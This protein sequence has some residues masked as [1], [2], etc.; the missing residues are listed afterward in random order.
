[1]Y[2]IITI[3]DA[4]LDTF[5]I[6]DE[7]T[8]LC[9]LERDNCK[10]CINYADKIQI[11]KTAQSVGGNAANVAIGCQRAGHKCAI[12]T[13]IGDDLNG[14]MVREEIQKNKV[15]DKLVK[16]IKNGETRY[17]VVLNYKGERTILSYYSKRNY[18]W[19]KLPSTKFIYYSSLGETFENIQNKLIA[20]L[21]KNPQTR[22]VVNPGSYQTRSGLKEFKKIF[23][24]TDI[25]FMNREEALR[26]TGS[27]KN[28]LKSLAM[29]I[30]KLGA[31]TAVITDGANGSLA[32]NAEETVALSS[33][34]TEIVD[35]TGAGDAF[36]SGFISAML[37]G[38]DLSQAVR[39][40]TANSTAV[41]AKIGAQAGLLNHT[42]ILKMIRKNEKIK[43]QINKV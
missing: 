34:P 11:K 42:E 3:G 19:P 4:T 27:D 13:E 1:M 43:P 25:I 33:Y 14:F 17:A 35:K 39:W 22:L 12:V 18:S 38:L 21:K 28:D 2:D 7:A 24:H 15:S 10:L 32:M 5:L 9:D 16:T 37:H 40:G 29:A 23:P 6:I 30:R 31:K 20:H 26:I 36:A 8:V 41:I